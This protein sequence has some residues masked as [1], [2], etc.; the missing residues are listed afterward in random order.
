M[1]IFMPRPEAPAPPESKLKDDMQELF[2]I[3]DDFKDKVPTGKYASVEELKN[4]W[5]YKKVDSF[6]EKLYNKPFGTTFQLAIS[7]MKN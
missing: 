4:V 5:R 3:K 1:N 2:A 7:M 6:M